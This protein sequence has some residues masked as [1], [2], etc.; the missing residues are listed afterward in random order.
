VF[1]DPTSGDYV[2]ALT[3]VTGL[4]S[5]EIRE[6]AS[7]AVESD[8]G[9]HG[10]FYLGR[11][12]VVLNGRVFG[13][14]SV[15]AREARLDKAR[16]ASL[17][18]RGDSILKWTP[19][20]AQEVFIPVRRQQ[21]FRESGGWVK[22]FQ[23]SMVSELA[24]IQ[25][26]ALVTSAAGVAKENNGNWPAFPTISI[27]GAS[28]DPTVSD[29][30]RIFTTTGLTLTGTETVAFDMR[31]HTGVFTAGARNGQS[32]NRYINFATTAWPYLTGQGT[33]QTFVLTGG[34]SL[35]FSYRHT[36]A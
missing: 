15:A 29:G 14:A 2:G 19:A 20:G 30:T 35:S 21:P 28:A 36:W 3:E 23:I 24:T 8:G 1:N 12:P 25:S 32:A 27:T 11:R 9:D 16:R 10:A 22:D 17:A 5:A 34:G 18:L 7:D 26:T 6:S 31:T 4:D 33:A 13:H